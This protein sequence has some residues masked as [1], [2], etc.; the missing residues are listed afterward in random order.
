[1]LAAH[2]GKRSAI[3]MT[4]RVDIP[5]LFAD[6]D[7]SV[8]SMLD[9]ES[10][11]RVLGHLRQRPSRVLLLGGDPRDT[12]AWT[13]FLPR[14]RFIR[15]SQEPVEHVRIADYRG[16][17]TDRARMDALLMAEAPAA[18]DVIIEDHNHFLRDSAALFLRLFPSHLASGG[19]YAMQSWGVSFNPAFPEGA[20][21]RLMV[22]PSAEP[23]GPRVVSQDI[24]L[25]GLAKA[26]ADHIA[27]RDIVAAGAAPEQLLPIRSL[28]FQP[29]FV[30]IERW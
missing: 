2:A 26:L 3:V 1:M 19:I 28:T 13:A 27:G 14:A 6:I 11:D 29:N 30:G 20:R 25:A 23:V 4:H 12:V 9:W 21:A 16:S 24:G 7:H 10:Y 8:M 15:L 17:P 18:F 22:R 5:S